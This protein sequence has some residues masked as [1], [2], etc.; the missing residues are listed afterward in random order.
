MSEDPGLW[1]QAGEWI[2]GSVAA[3]IALVW[4]DN[5]RRVDKVED[6]IESKADKEE[7]DRQRDNITSIFDKIEGVQKQIHAMHVDILEKI[8]R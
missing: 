3:L 6:K 7:M 4:A 1:S 2:T 5:K 8:Q